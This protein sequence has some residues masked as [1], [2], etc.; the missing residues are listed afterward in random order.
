MAEPLLELVDVSKYY[1]GAQ[2]VVAALN[3]VSL[4]FAR[5]EFVAVTG[6]SGSGKSTLANVLGGILPYESGEMLFMGRP[7]SHY[8][9][10]DWERYRR[11]RVSFIS[12]S[13]GILPGATVMSN[14][15]SALRLAGMDRSETKKAA[16]EIL[17]RVELWELR[18]RRAAKLSSGQ[19][20]RL[21]IARALA[22]PAPIL[23]AD[24]PTGNLD[25][26][27]SRK[28]IELLSGA[29]KERLVILI[30][31]EF[32]EARD[33]ATRHIVIQE[34]KAASDTVLRPAP[35]PGPAPRR[36]KSSKKPLSPYVAGLQ[37]R[38]RPVWS[39]LMSLI[40]VLTAFSVFAFLGVF[41]LSLDDT[42]TRIYDRSAFRNG[43]KTRLLAAPIQGSLTQA[44][45][46]S[47]LKIPH[48]TALEVWG[49]ACDAQYGYRGNIDYADI[50]TVVTDPVTYEQIGVDT[51][52]R[53]ADTAPFVATVPMLPEGRSPV[54]TGRLPENFHEVLTSDPNL[55]IGD[56]VTVYL[57][58][59]NSWDASVCV[60]VEM[61]VVGTTDYGEGLVFHE[62]VGRFFRQGM[63]LHGSQDTPYRFL[64][65]PREDLEGLPNG[66]VAGVF[67]FYE[68]KARA[69]DPYEADGWFI[70]QNII[71]LNDIGYPWVDSGETNT[72]SG[73][74]SSG[75][76]MSETVTAEVDG[77]PVETE[78]PVYDIFYNAVLQSRD[79][80][81]ES[82]PVT[83]LML[84]Q[85]DASWR[86][87]RLMEVSPAMFDR[88]TWATP[89]QISVTIED[90][91]YTDRV[92]DELK[93]MG[94]AAISV[95]RLGSTQQDPV[96]AAERSQT[97]K[98]CLLALIAVAI[99]QVVLLRVMFSA[100]A[101]TLRLLANIGLTGKTGKRAVLWQ[102]L[103]FTVL[104][105]ALGVLG[106]GL[107]GRAG[108]EKIAELIRYLPL[109][110]ALALSAVHI[111]LTALAAVWILRYLPRQVFPLA[112]RYEDLEL[113]EEAEA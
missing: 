5:G 85:N 26:E 58:D 110:Y 74:T 29:A 24:E 78:N 46:E 70:G 67:S 91:A 8:D 72:Y 28:V 30:T 96:L 61:T 112:E 55:K 95:Y 27:N 45:Y 77:V 42:S 109:K 100:Q 104:G 99:L 15:V 64:Y 20:Q 19:K 56:R 111:A 76:P 106:I 6:E 60:D 11:D 73:F 31:H 97:L 66:H 25:A 79:P 35:E 75:A 94:L 80:D 43:S 44:D 49:D 54:L 51:T 90:Y 107:A 69:T 41:I 38:S 48:V 92:L 36:A 7:T 57:A 83:L 88:L 16:E 82:D 81:N 105:Q 33:V 13:Y 12:Q 52:H 34:G 113:D 59:F 53:V 9:G 63:E 89:R 14:V 23:I 37:I 22:K 39:A 68:G 4:R 3:S 2:S 21:S 40:A 98:V 84:E 62:D 32:D 50:N 87:Q 108:V 47:I 17:R 93:D 86:P 1:T 71:M 18:R 10:E 101:D 103:F 65:L 102:L